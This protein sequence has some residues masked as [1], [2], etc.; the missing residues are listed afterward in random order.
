M[1]QHEERSGALSFDLH[2]CSDCGS[3]FR[4]VDL[5]QTTGRQGAPR[6][7]CKNCHS[8]SMAEEIA[9]RT[10]ASFTLCAVCQTSVPVH[11]SVRSYIPT[12]NKAG[13][14]VGTKLLRV[15]RYCAKQ[16]AVPP[17]CRQGDHRSV[18][19]PAAKAW[20]AADF[21]YEPLPEW[22]DPGVCAD[23]RKPLLWVETRWVEMTWGLLAS[24]WQ[25][26]GGRR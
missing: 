4:R 13:A 8:D 12:V 10:G 20:S 17:W 19:T 22:S 6:L 21:P 25:R 11:E 3:S 16:D 15:C 23:C 18:T 5:V 26:P 1:S 2:V 9:K 7:L 24:E 14:A